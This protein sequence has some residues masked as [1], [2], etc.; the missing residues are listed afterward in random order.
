M[1]LYRDCQ[2]NGLKDINTR[3][4]SVK[5]ETKMNVLKI[6][7]DGA[8]LHHMDSRQSDKIKDTGQYK[9]NFQRMWQI[10][11]LNPDYDVFFEISK[12]KQIYKKAMEYVR[13]N[14]YGEIKMNAVLK[15]ENTASSFT[16]PLLIEQ[17]MSI[18]EGSSRKIDKFAKRQ[19]RKNVGK[20]DLYDIF[21]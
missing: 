12:T 1:N 6:C 3:Y 21:R 20:P 13:I 16:K 9:I 17:G 4:K 2:T 5:P 11:A 19:N 8:I 14:R 15:V 18:E 7:Y 10:L